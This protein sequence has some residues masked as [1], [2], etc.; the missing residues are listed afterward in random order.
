VAEVTRTFASLTETQ[1]WI[2]EKDIP[3]FTP[4]ILRGD[5][6]GFRTPAAY[7]IVEVGPGNPKEEQPFIQTANVLVSKPF[8]YK[9]K[10]AVQI[11]G[12]AAFPVGS[13]IQVTNKRTGGYVVQKKTKVSSLGTAALILPDTMQSDPISIKATTWYQDRSGYVRQ[14]SSSVLTTVPLVR[15]KGDQKLRG[16]DYV[17]VS[18]PAGLDSAPAKDRVAVMD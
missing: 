9:G 7:N 5:H 13:V 18:R 12:V 8:E 17:R 1:N 10:P 15:S 14:S 16:L 2:I 6:F 3:A 11:L 4:V